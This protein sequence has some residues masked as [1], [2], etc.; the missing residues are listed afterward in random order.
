[1]ACWCPSAMHR[2][3]SSG[4]RLLRMM[5]TQAIRRNAYKLGREMTWGSV[6]RQ[7]IRS[8]E[9]ARWMRRGSLAKDLCH[10]NARP[11]AA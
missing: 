5:L 8:F 1:V 10:K 9:L 6:A 11:A 3:C 4:D 2:H 7:Y